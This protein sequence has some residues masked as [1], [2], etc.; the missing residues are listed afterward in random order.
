MNQIDTELQVSSVVHPAT[1][2]QCAVDG[3]DR[4]VVVIFEAEEEAWLASRIFEFAHARGLPVILVGVVPNASGEAELRRHLVTIAAFLRE[5]TARMGAALAPVEIQMERG[6]EWMGRIKS[7]LHRGDRL[8]CYSEKT[9]GILGRP[10]SEVLASGLAMPIYTFERLR[11]ESH[12]RQNRLAQV[13]SWV[14]SFASIAGFFVVQAR[15]V[16]AVQ[17]WTQTALLLITLG[18]EAGLIWLVNSLLAQS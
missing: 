9:V 16:I 14:A 7:R 8:A 5:E 18:A 15:I 10:P 3:A 2:S 13:T 12:D 6:R 1:E 11:G 17:G 4:L